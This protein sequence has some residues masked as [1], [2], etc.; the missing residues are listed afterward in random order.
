MG[1]LLSAARIGLH[2]DSWLLVTTLEIQGG[3]RPE[4]QF[5]AVFSIQSFFLKSST[6]PSHHTMYIYIYIYVSWL[7][8]FPTM[9]YH[10]PQSMR[11]N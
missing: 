9:G 4:L 1:Y 2:P 10:N 11:I 7:I 5:C 6:I 8:G 3:Q